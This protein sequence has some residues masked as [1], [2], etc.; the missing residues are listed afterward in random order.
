MK[1]NYYCSIEV[2]KS[3]KIFLFD[4]FDEK[5]ELIYN[6]NS[7]IKNRNNKI[8]KEIFF[9]YYDTKERILIPINKTKFNIF[10]DLYYDDIKQ[11]KI[12]NFLTKYK[13]EEYA[14]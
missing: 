3:N 8:T 4:L 6:G 10:L 12:I 14:I 11:L 1:S 5:K 2:N 9:K 7:Q 13:L